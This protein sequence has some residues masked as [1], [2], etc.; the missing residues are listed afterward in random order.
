ML[1]GVSSWIRHKYRW[2]AELYPFFRSAFH[3]GRRMS[4]EQDNTSSIQK[5]EILLFSTM[6]NEGHRLEFFLDYY[7]KMG[8]SHFFLVDNNSDDDTAEILSRH[9]DVTRFLAKDGYKETNFGMHWLNYLLFKYGRGHWCMTCDPDEFLVYPHCNTRDL[10]DLTSYLES[11]R[12]DSFFTVMIDMYGEGP[13]SETWY[14]PGSDPLGAC[15]Y[16]DQSGYSKQYNH[17]M[18]NLFVQGGVR[19][20]V[21]A[22][23]APASAP[24][25]NKV[26]LVKWKWNYA[27][28]SSMHMALPRR[29]NQCIDERKVTGGILHFKFISQLNDKVKQEMVAKQHYN[30]SAEYKQYGRV[31]DN[32]DLLFHPQVS[33]RYESWETLE[34]LGLINKGEW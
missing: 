10:K 26:P 31:I 33:T 28:V 29:L 11:I 14:E 9:S 15:P 32:R 12:Q 5:G 2:G 30:D 7:R 13:V 34:H 4:L 21:F 25:L 6:K 22:K 24:A 8:V 20:R 18:R 27:Y 16:F 3:Y 19:R 1:Q 23:E 17:D